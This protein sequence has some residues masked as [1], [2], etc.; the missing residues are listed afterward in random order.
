MVSA[1]T[2]RR[3][4]ATRRAG[5]SPK[6]RSG[7]SSPRRRVH[8][9]ATAAHAAAIP[10]ATTVLAA[11]EITTRLRRWWT[12]RW[13]WSR[14]KGASLVKVERRCCANHRPRRFCHT[15]STLLRFHLLLL[16]MI[17][18]VVGMAWR[19]ATPRGRPLMGGGRTTPV[20][21]RRRASCIWITV[22]I[23]W[24]MVPTAAASG[25]GLS[26]APRRG[27]RRM[28]PGWRLWSSALVLVTMVWWR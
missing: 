28:V 20:V 10:M 4:T 16:R 27:G 25:I 22:P 18:V 11:A 23:G 12:T 24:M 13:R 26:A 7:R 1:A 8:G 3:W 2:L 15:I 6:D 17:P 19:R 5:S 9:F 21:R 14:G